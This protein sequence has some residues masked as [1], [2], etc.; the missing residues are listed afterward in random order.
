M[1][2][3]FESLLSVINQCVKDLKFGKAQINW[4]TWT[5]T[6]QKKITDYNTWQFKVNILHVKWIEVVQLKNISLYISTCTVHN[7]ILQAPIFIPE[8]GCILHLVSDVRGSRNTLQGQNTDAS[9]PESAIYTHPKR[10]ED[11]NKV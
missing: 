8:F 1:I 4:S 3:T 10:T 2:K 7:I 6:R 11:P 5:Y 9:T